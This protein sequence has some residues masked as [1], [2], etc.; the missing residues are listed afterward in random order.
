MTISLPAN[1]D[2]N[3]LKK[4]AKKLLRHYRENSADA[5]ASVKEFHPK[6]EYFKSLR[7]AQLVVARRHGYVDWAALS[8]AV[9]IAA[10]AAKPLA[11]KAELFLRLGCVQYSGTDAL[12]NYQRASELLLLYPDISEFSIYTALVA[13]NKQ[14]VLHYLQSS[15]QLASSMGGPLNWP[16]LLYVTYGRIQMPDDTRDAVEIAQLLIDNGADANAH[17]ILNDSYRF[18][19]LTGAMGEGEGGINQP[20]HQHADDLVQLLLDAGANPN[21]G[22]GLYNTIFT[23]SVDKW[24]ALFI[25]NGLNATHTLN[26]DDANNNSAQ[27]T[28]DYLLASAVSGG[29][30]ERVKTLLAAGADP[31]TINGYNGRAVHTNALLAGHESIAEMLISAGASPQVLSLEE[32]FRLACVRENYNAITS[33]LE[34]HPYLKEDAELLHNAVNVCHARVYW[35]LISLGFDL[36]G[37][38]ESGRTV[39]HQFALKNDAEQVSYLLKQGA[40]LSLRD[41]IHEYS[42]VGF[43][44]YT[45][46]NDVLY[47]LL[48]RSENFMEVVC[49]AYLE[50]AKVLLDR[51]P[52]LALLRT[53]Q[54]HTTLHV[55][56]SWLQQEPDSDTSKALIEL[57]IANG[58][59]INAKNEEAQTPV[60]FSVALGADIMADLLAEFG[61]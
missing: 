34:Q 48:D 2:I 16:A 58:A 49:C 51:N 52:E 37:Q 3:L 40:D 56:G 13:N 47:L 15:P 60:E 8:E 1:P 18:T 50:R 41:H 30:G 23:D 21:D 19:A 33:L 32:Q 14:A 25:R 10:Y 5:I 35:K 57:L 43:A 20:P 36:N 53:P 11:E 22:Q 45:G 28:F 38:D 29:R 26:W 39:L 24:L 59:D 44:A 6:P 17:I 7:D 42:P 55:I 12:R 54:G 27:T 9:A 31:D 46:A 61:E 4:Q